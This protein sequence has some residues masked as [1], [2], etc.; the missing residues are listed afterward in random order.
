[1]CGIV[2]VIN[3]DGA[4]VAEDLLAR[5][6][7]RLRHRGPDAVGVARP[8]PGVGLGHTRLKVIDLSEAAN[9][10]MANPQRTVWL[11][12]NGE[13]Y[14]FREL[15]RELE[16]YGRRFRSQSDTEVALQAYEQWGEE[17]VSR[18]DGMFALA[19]VDLARRRL[20]LARDRTGKKP[21]FYWADAHRIVFASEI[22]ALLAHPAVP[23][24]VEPGSLPLY[25][26]Y[27]Y[28]PAP[29]T[30]YRGIASLAPATR[31]S[32]EWPS[33]SR[34]EQP[35]WSWP[36]PEAPSRLSRAQARQGVRERLT[37]AVRKRLIADVPLGAFLSGGIDST[38]VVG[39]MSRLLEQPVHTFSIGFRGSPDYDETA[40]AR[41]AARHVGSRHT[42]FLVE[43]KAFALLER[44]VWHH[45][46]P[47][48]DVS[49]IPTY[50]LCQLARQHVTVA[51]NGD[52]GDEVFAGYRWFQAA[53]LSTRAPRW[54]FATL[55]WGLRQ[56]P[57][58]S[59]RLRLLREA[60]RFCEAARHPWEEQ[61]VRWVAY[62]PAP[63]A[64]LHPDVLSHASSNGAWL[65][66]AQRH[67]ARVAKR[68][69]M[70]QALYF[71]SQEYLPGDV[72]VKTD[73]CSMAHG[74]ETR[75]PFLDTELIEFAARLPDR[76][77]LDG[78]CTKVILKEACHDL[79]PPAIARRRKQ[80]FRVPLDH[81][82]RTEL[83]QPVHDLLLS[84]Q[85]RLRRYLRPEA[86]TSLWQEQMAGSRNHGMPLWSLLTLE[87][88]LRML[89]RNAWQEAPSTEALHT[90]HEVVT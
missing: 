86:V 78:G 64:L 11:V 34:H 2:G 44:L 13:I 45:D 10:P 48:G 37:D 90:T 41:A 81:W 83:Q 3:F 73:R 33:G 82:F 74:L 87:V 17:C 31:L 15:R 56:L 72:N 4:M 80:G 49:A 57:S 55:A 12:F 14:N 58:G 7:G 18:L 26:T 88:W 35:Y 30:F 8:A 38:I 39:L 62:F 19:V 65:A 53:V 76:M 79:L 47:F 68:S 25:L 84:P 28:V 5:M 52:G 75:S 27:G 59:Q 24:E 32:L 77:K 63:A 89:E 67:L 1:M 43:P 36:V 6:A 66:P 16:G 50:L 29:G 54:V 71:N 85:A 61:L 42:E 60:R 40:H 22:K 70:A 21:L 23:C 9:Q 69:P 20:L 51:L 46:Q